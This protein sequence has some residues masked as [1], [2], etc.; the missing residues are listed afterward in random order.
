M[1]LGG[2][3]LARFIDRLHA[4]GQTDGISVDVGTI[5]ALWYQMV[6]IVHTLHRNAIVHMDLK[7]DN[8]ILFGSTVKIADLGVSRKIT[9]LG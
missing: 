8:L 5:K 6:S 1:E 2:E 4:E 9:V 7:P 3:N